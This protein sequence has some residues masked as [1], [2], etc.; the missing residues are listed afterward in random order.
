MVQ[1]NLF[2]L[3]KCPCCGGH[4]MYGFFGDVFCIEDNDCAWR[5]VMYV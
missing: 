2:T 3:T 4:I 5:E 1:I